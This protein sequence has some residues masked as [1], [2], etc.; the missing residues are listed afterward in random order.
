MARQRGV[1][2]AVVPLPEPA[3]HRDGEQ[4]VIVVTFAPM[5]VRV[6]RCLGVDLHPKVQQR[7]AQGLGHRESGG[8]LQALS[9]RVEDKFSEVRGSEVRQ[10][11]SDLGH[12]GGAMRMVENDVLGERRTL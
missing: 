5:L 1:G 7:T 6:V 11:L 9:N 8:N 10:P 3:R 12:R 4:Q 2:V